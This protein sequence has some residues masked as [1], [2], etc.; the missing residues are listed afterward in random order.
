VLVATDIAARG[1]DIDQLPHVVNY[2]LPNV[3]EDYV[4][5]IGRTGRAGA[6]GEAISLV[7]VDEHAFLRDIE[8]L[9][10]REIESEIVAGFEPDR[11]A[12]A[13]PIQ[14]RPQRGARAGNP[15]GAKSRQRSAGASHNA[16][17]GAATH[18][19]KRGDE[20]TA[21]GKRGTQ[22][23]PPRAPHA[24]ASPSPAT[25]VRT[26]AKSPNAAPRTPAHAAKPGVRRFGGRY[27]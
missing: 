23:A 10:K 3:P 9:I 20:R 2:D 15:S 5:R 8:R 17:G 22:G 24:T 12:V 16:R 11:R 14:Q 19:T 26:P 18:A 13:Q 27:K 6:T 25:Q 1:I 7:C 4:H 21:Q